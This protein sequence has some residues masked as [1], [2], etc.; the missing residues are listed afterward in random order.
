MGLH[1][2]FKED[3]PGSQNLF[4]SL[5]LCDFKLASLLQRVGC[6]RLYPLELQLMDY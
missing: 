5:P 1:A 6:H 2:S 4:S 3:A